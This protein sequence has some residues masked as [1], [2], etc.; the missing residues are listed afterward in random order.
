MGPRSTRR[1]AAT[2]AALA[3]VL[4]AC[5]GDG[6]TGDD[7]AVEGAEGGDDASSAPDGDGAPPEELRVAVANFPP[8]AEPWTGVGSPGQYLWSA[9]FDAL[10]VIGEDGTPQ[11]ALA[12]S[13]DNVDDLTW[14]FTLRQDVTFHDGTPMTADD[15]VGT[16]ELLLSEEGAAAYGSHVGNYPF[17]DTVTAPDESTIRI[18]TTTPSPVL[19]AAVSIV[20]VVPIDYFEEVGASG[21]ATEPVGTGP[22]AATSW[23]SERVQLERY[24]DSWREVPVERL[25]FLNLNDPAART[26]AL[27]SGQVDV[28]L[29]A[30]ADAAVELENAG[31]TNY[32]GR[33]GRL[34]SLALITNEG[35][36][37][38]EVDVRRALNHAIDKEAIAEALVGGLTGPAA[39]PPEGV[40]GF[41]D[42]RAAY[43]YD[44]ELAASLL[45]DAGYGD[46]FTIEAEV[47][48]GAFPA[49]RE[50]YEAAAGY[51]QEVG[52]DLQLTEIDFSQD[53]L[54][55]YSGAGGADWAGNAFGSTWVAPPL[56]DAVRPL[57]QY[58][59]DWSNPWYCDEDLDARL[60]A[61]NT[62]LDPDVR[63]TELAG[64]LDTVAEDAPVVWLVELIELWVSDPDVQGWE[65]HNFNPTFEQIS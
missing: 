38:A 4:T 8:S 2:V 12:E 54:P 30:S 15:V 63:D 31:Y 44:P 59:C 55:K 11:P 52:V 50:I 42:G 1:F 16:F 29:A 41:D 53:W 36:P 10:T 43:E 51:L 9:V 32:V 37:L 27:Q 40:N 23:A 62:E 7:G 18:E 61:V 6:T 33:S 13:W 48:L 14:D 3:L 65:V 64:V 17:I 5:G 56:L 25:E 46:G 39:W 26:Q 20:Y 58:R 19:P 24:E 45:D 22:Y 47:T 21:F 35:G 60:D 34:M 28:I 49:D 57:T